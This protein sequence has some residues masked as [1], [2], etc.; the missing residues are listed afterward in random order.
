[1]LWAKG[2]ADASEAIPEAPVTAT[3]SKSSPARAFTNHAQINAA[4]KQYSLFSGKKSKKQNWP[5]T[6]PTS[7]Y[8][9]TSG[10][11]RTIELGES[12]ADEEGQTGA[13][14]TEQ[15]RCAKLIGEHTVDFTAMFGSWLDS[16]EKVLFAQFGSEI[17]LPKPLVKT[18]A[19]GSISKREP[20][21]GRDGFE[22]ILNKDTAQKCHRVFECDLHK[23]FKNFPSLLQDNIPGMETIDSEVLKQVRLG[24][25]YPVKVTNNVSCIDGKQCPFAEVS[26]GSDRVSDGSDGA[27]EVIIVGTDE[28]EDDFVGEALDLPI[29]KIPDQ[30]Y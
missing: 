14:M 3:P 24:M 22:M 26:D 11:F 4:V 5:V 1:M 25:D 6:S 18:D 21:L 16:Q 15:E 29:I 30:N 2:T 20:K 10:V 12:N 23:M 28:N 8:K 7:D 19:D 27:V 9:D 17:Y 13:N